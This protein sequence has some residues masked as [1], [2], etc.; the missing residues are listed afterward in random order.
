MWEGLEGFQSGDG[1]GGIRN[2]ELSFGNSATNN[3]FGDYKDGFMALWTEKDGAAV[4]KKLAKEYNYEKEKKDSQLQMDKEAGK[5]PEKRMGPRLRIISYRS[6][7]YR[8]HSIFQRLEQ[9]EPLRMGQCL[10]QRAMA[11]KR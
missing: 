7:T 3:K 1:C 4:E 6:N 9:L 10:S 11:S 2:D 8:L 5:T